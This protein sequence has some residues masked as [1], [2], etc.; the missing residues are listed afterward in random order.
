MDGEVVAIQLN[1]GIY[2]SLRG[3]AALLWQTLDKPSDSAGLARTLAAQFEVAA[4]QAGKDTEA[5]LQQLQTEQLIIAADAASTGAPAAAAGARQPYAAPQL[6][7]YADLQDL[8]LLDPI[9]EV[10]EQGWPHQ[11]KPD[12]PA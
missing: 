2:Y 11:P 7:R 1:T 4:E 5:F 9:H 12:K 8:L 10:G 6:E 3:P